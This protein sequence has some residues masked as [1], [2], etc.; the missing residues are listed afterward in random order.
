MGEAADRCTTPQL[1]FCSLPRGSRQGFHCDCKC[2]VCRLLLDS[3]HVTTCTADARSRLAFQWMIVH[4]HGAS[5]VRLSC[6]S[7]THAPCY[8]AD[9]HSLQTGVQS[10]CQAKDYLY[11]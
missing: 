9:L 1:D 11:G 5:E 6:I 2:L 3:I 4:M 8:M 10:S 7:T